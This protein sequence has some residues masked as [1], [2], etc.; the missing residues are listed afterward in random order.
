M[1]KTPRR[2]TCLLPKRLFQAYGGLPRSNWTPMVVKN[3]MIVEIKKRRHLIIP[4][5]AKNL[6]KPGY[7]IT[8]CSLTIVF[9]RV[10]FKMVSGLLKNSKD[11]QSAEFSR[12][13]PH[14]AQPIL[15][16]C[17]QTGETENG[18]IRLYFFLRHM[19]ERPDLAQQVRIL[20]LGRHGWKNVH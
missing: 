6:T 1:K 7:A 9:T 16:K 17:F 11:C 12:L 14:V 4:D 8:T 13:F 2:E 18:N 10:C 15:N 5:A 20:D 19:L 3:R